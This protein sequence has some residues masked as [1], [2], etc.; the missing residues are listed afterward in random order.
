[1]NNYQQDYYDFQYDDDSYDYYQ[2][3]NYSQNNG[4]QQNNGYP[5]NNRVLA[6][7]KNSRKRNSRY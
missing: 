4:Y 2:N 3:N 6:N 5:Q 7:R 1:M